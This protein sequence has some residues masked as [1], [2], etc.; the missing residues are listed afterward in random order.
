[1]SDYSEITYE[2]AQG[3]AAITFSQ[4]D[5][6]NPHLVPIWPSPCR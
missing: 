5:C 3:V 6:L 1:M 4:P 2:V